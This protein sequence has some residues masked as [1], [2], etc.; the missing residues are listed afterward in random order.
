MKRL[1]LLS[2]FSMLL[3]SAVFAPVAMAQEAAPGEVVV[4]SATLGPGG[5]V[6]VT[7]TIQCVEGYNWLVDI[8]V[9]QRTNGNV[10]NTASSL[11]DGYTTCTT[12]EL[13][14]F[15]VT[16]FGQRQFHGGPASVS[17]F[18]EVCPPEGFPCDR[19]GSVVAV[20]LR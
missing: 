17:T 18:G 3:A 16:G 10:F 11:Q 12:N 1:A 9:R 15:T 8:T 14:D 2:V 6:T 19:T 13:T 4:Q 20:R 7:G 5:S